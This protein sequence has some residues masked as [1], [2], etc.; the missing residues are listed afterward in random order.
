MTSRGEKIG[1]TRKL[2]NLENFIVVI[3]KQVFIPQTKL[4]E[5]RG[6][7]SIAS[8][9]SY[10]APPASRKGPGR[11]NGRSRSSFLKIVTVLKESEK[12]FTVFIMLSALF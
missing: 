9:R 4:A 1:K 5:L 3:K 10:R 2:K 8:A 7:F 6:S 12:F 11:K